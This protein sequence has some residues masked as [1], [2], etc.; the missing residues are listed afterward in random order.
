MP[1]N[2]LSEYPTIPSASTLHLH[3]GHISCYS[4]ALKSL[5]LEFILTS[6]DAIDS[7][8][9]VLFLSND[10]NFMCAVILLFSCALAFF[11]STIGL[12]TLRDVLEPC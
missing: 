12:H 4:I 11:S 6:S 8:D 7:F 2:N 5:R 3:C 10:A 1:L 9:S